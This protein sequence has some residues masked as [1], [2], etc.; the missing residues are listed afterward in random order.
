MNKISGKKTLDKLDEKYSAFI[1][2]NE[3]KHM[4]QDVMHL[5]SLVEEYRLEACYYHDKFV[6]CLY[7]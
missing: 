6:E 2:E 1:K 3:N 4:T 5:I 7:S